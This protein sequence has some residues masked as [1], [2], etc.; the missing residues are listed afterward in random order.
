[1]LQENGFD[2]LNRI[3]K[4]ANLYLTDFTDFFENQS[5]KVC[6]YIVLPYEERSRILDPARLMLGNIGD[7]GENIGIL[8]ASKNKCL[9][10]KAANPI[11]IKIRRKYTPREFIAAIRDKFLNIEIA[12]S[13]EER[14]TQHNNVIW[15]REKNGNPYLHFEVWL[16]RKRKTD[17]Y[18][19]FEIA[20]HLEWGVSWLKIARTAKRA[21][22]I[23]R[24]MVEARG[25][26]KKK[27]YDFK[28]QRAWG[29]AW[30]RLYIDRKTISAVLDANGLD[31]VLEHLKVLTE[32][33]TPSLNK[34]N[35]GRTRRRELEED[36]K[37]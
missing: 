23:R 11:S 9:L 2:F 15:F 35:W 10:D 32:T 34:I 18:F 8:S 13:L 31:D 27:G 3:S 30:S 37:E 36:T 5:I 25:I 12:R 6:F 21:A 33:L 22:K 16:K 26:L 7:F 28:Y 17:P 24:K 14:Q 4:E 20:F 1:M 29:K 19:T